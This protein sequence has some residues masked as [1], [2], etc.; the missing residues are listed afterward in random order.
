MRMK[1]LSLLIAGFSSLALSQTALSQGESPLEEIVVISSRVPI[2]LRQIGTSVSVMTQDEIEA[3]GNLSLSDVLRQ[4]P[5]I[6]TSNNGGAGKATA[7]RIRGEEGFRTL[8]I[9]DGIRLQDPSSTQIGTQF[10]HLMSNGI[11]RVEV[12]RG[13]QGLSYG[14]DAG[15]VVNISTQQVEEGLSVNL[16]AQA[17]RFETEQVSGTIGGGNE[18]AD[19]FLSVSDYQTDGFNTRD[20]DSVL[21]DNDGYDNST[22]HARLG[23]DLTDELRF[24]LVHRDVD[25]D[26]KF[27]GCFSGTTVHDCTGAFELQASRIAA[28]YNGENFTHSLAY[29][30]TETD[31]EN[32]ALGVSS[33]T[34]QGELTR[35]EYVG[36]ATNLPGFDLVF[37]LDQEEAENN[38]IG[39]DNTGVY[40]EYLS[41]FS[42]DVF[43]TAGVRHDDNDDFGTNTSYRLSGAYLIE[44]ASGG[45]LKYKASFGT[46]FRAPAPAEIAY[47]VG[48]FAFPPASGVILQQEESEGYEF[49]V[50]YVVGN[51]LHL[52]AVYFD[53]EVENAIFFDLASFSGYLQDVGTSTSKGVELNG[54]FQLSDAWDLKVNYTYNDTERPNGQQR[55]RRP[56]NLVNLGLSYS[57]MG[58]RLNINGFYRI[59]RDS[60]DEIFGVPDPV[61]LDDFE[62]LDLSANY[63]ITNNIQI[64]GRIENAFDESYQEIT[65]F[66]T[67]GA[68]AYIGFKLNFSSL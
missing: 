22:V 31:R 13:P 33:F 40:L 36:S 68:S 57:G 34:A 5:A 4:M 64:Y 62:V 35:F 9:L 41:D 30:S 63:Q 67:P 28:S 58:D 42:D 60:I 17:G 38:G 50:E 29:A 23:F 46:G 10:E 53:Q 47:N 7:L 59:S 2:P 20:S 55:R 1:K 49:G 26:T 11:G 3:H 39:R 43:M 54:E 19:F 18:Q 6:A 66:N 61:Q 37:G 14:A 56:E 25:S 27:D 24:D 52:E 32:F 44:T 51:D 12:L 21:Q 48:P 65:G 45:T 16:D 8:T 15:G